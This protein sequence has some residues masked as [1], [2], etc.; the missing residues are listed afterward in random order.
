MKRILKLTSQIEAQ[1]IDVIGS[2][3]VYSKK[4][5]LYIGQYDGVLN[6][7]I[8]K[9][10]LYGHKDE[11]IYLTCSKS[12]DLILSVDLE[13]FVIVHELQNLVFLRNFQLP[14]EKEWSRNDAKI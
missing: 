11:I 4:S 3:L 7:L 13:G 14:L 2:Y 5:S 6:R 9:K 1:C 8:N 10:T 12:L